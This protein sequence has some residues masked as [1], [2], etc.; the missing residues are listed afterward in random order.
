MKL[1]IKNKAMDLSDTDKFVHKMYEEGWFH[2][3]S[4]HD[5]RGEIR[6]F[7][8]KEGIEYKILYKRNEYFV[9]IPKE[10]LQI[11]VRDN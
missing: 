7:V 2:E 1:I 6:C 9:Y 4:V 10:I 3:W 11:C 5:E 8:D